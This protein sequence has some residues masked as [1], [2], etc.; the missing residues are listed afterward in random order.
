MRQLIQNWIEVWLIL[1]YDHTQVGRFRIMKLRWKIVVGLA[2]FIV[3]CAV[4]LVYLNYSARTA[5]EETRRGLRKEGFKTDL[6][7]FDFS[8]SPEYRIRE[9]ALTAAGNAI[10]NLRSPG[11]L[12]LNLV[13]ASGNDS[14]IVLWKQEKLE[15]RYTYN[16]LLD[17]WPVL[18]ET[19]DA[20]S[21]TL[22]AACEALLSGPFR[23][24]LN[25]SRGNAIPL[26]HLL[27]IKDLTLAFGVRVVLEL[28]NNNKD[29]A[30]TNL[31]AETRLVTAYELEPAEVSHMVRFAC[32]AIAFNATWQALQA[33]GWTDDRLARLKQEW[34]SV[35]FFSGLPETA[36]FNR[37][38][39]VAECQR[40][41]MEPLSGRPTF[42][43][44]F[45]SPRDAWLNLKYYWKQVHY[46]VSGTYEDEKA[47]L[48][49][50]RDRELELRSAMKSPTW[51]EMRELPA[52]TN[53]ISFQSKY[54]SRIQSMLNLRNVSLGLMR[55]GKGLLGR[56][57]EA[58]ARRRL[59]VTAI[60]LERFR[61]RNGFYPQTLQ[62]LTPGFLKDVLPDFMNGQPLRYR[63]MDDGHFV[64]YSVG[65]DCVDDG[66]VARLR[67]GPEYIRSPPGFGIRPGGDLVWSRPASVAETTSYY[68]EQQRALAEEI[69]RARLEAEAAER[70]EEANRRAAVEKLL[71]MKQSVR[72]K[73]PWFKGQP[74]IETLRNRNLPDS[75]VLTLD[76]MLTLKQTAGN[77]EYG[78]VTFEVPISYDALSN[79]GTLDLLV[80]A[81]PEGDSSSRG[82][83]VQDCSRATNG[84]CLLLWN[85]SF[86]PPGQ[87]ALQARLLCT[88]SEN[89]WNTFEVKGA[90]TP[91]FSSNICQ[92]DP[93]NTMFD[94]S[95]ATMY[96]RL[97]ESNG[98]YTVEIKSSSGEIVKTFTG[99]TTNGIIQFDWN[100]IDKDGRRYT[101]ASFESVFHV[102]LPGSGRTQAIIG[103]GKWAVR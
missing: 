15:Q 24:N 20:D 88:D 71:A 21:S 26:P 97:P 10:R 56:A 5:V 42:R 55:E 47:L 38:A 83:E 33:D 63:L 78:I 14:L 61:G 93:Y 13:V 70:S 84:N 82:A 66:G 86:D 59:I 65:L 79:V 17:F 32:T 49:Y 18:Y 16:Q 64:L 1:D 2:A 94:S 89:D 98:L 67:E 54:S 77:D 62:E 43:M 3:L 12:D 41:R 23:F 36:A 48:L 11:A 4:L 81:D 22:D 34:E 50:F 27:G 9:D 30:W 53:R 29:A 31:L 100:L 7:D 39:S 68:E 87:H 45:R 44:L 90:V 37:A 69:L 103:P 73:D 96:A 52:V 102:T 8:T 19:L 75:S 57:A 51:L 72:L 60:A 99:N 74:L 58:E 6:S 95:G 25:A 35:D 40:E 92:F 80:D 28:H 91:Y 46:R 76:E 85:T 101:N